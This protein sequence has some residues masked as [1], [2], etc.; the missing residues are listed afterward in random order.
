VR[1]HDID[2]IPTEF[3]DEI[4]H[5]FQVYKDLEARAATAAASS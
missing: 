1:V 2:D 5:S 4:E 3:R